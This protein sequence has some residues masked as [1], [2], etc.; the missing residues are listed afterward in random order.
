MQYA[1]VAD[2]TARFGERELIQLTDPDLQ[3]VQTDKAERAI[4]DAQAFADA[5]VGVAYRLPL[6]GCAKPA[7][8]PGN[9]QAVERVAPPQLTRIVCDVARYYLYDALAPEHEVYL[10][11]KAA[12]HELQQ[13]ADGRAVLACPWGGTPGQL[14][15]GSEPGEGEVLHGFS[16]RTITDDEMRGY[17]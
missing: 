15:A 10:R 16:P 3:A 11:Y 17:A 2:M 1:T 9:P 8:V 7:P 12:Q 13:L 4:G 14:V 6:V 5:F